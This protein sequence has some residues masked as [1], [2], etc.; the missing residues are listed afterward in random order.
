[1]NKNI[2]PV[3]HVIN[4]EQALVN[5]GIC[6]GCGCEKVFFINHQISADKMIEIALQAKKSSGLWIGVNILGTSPETALGYNWEFDAVW[7]DQRVTIE[8]PI[9]EGAIFGGIAFKYQRD[10]HIW[11]NPELL[12]SAAEE[13]KRCTTIATTSGMGTGHQAPIEKIRVIKE[14]LGDHPLAVASGITPDNIATYAPYVDYF[15]VASSI[16]DREERIQPADLKQLLYKYD[17]A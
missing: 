14:A 6:L 3:I 2:I 15:L 12:M 16:T 17:R 10:E 13:A 5:Y 4:R 7:I 11:K 8:E 1:M 9:F